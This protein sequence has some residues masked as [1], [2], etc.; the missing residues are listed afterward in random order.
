M[1]SNLLQPRYTK[2]ILILKEET[3]NCGM[4]DLHHGC[5][6]EKFAAIV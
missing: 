6:T 3:G 5:V 4:E 2:Y 1:N